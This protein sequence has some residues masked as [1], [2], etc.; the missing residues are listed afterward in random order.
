MKSSF[1]NILFMR[2]EQSYALFVDEVWKQQ[3]FSSLNSSFMQIVADAF[4][5]LYLIDI[6]ETL[7]IFYLNE[8]LVKFDPIYEQAKQKRTVWKSSSVNLNKIYIFCFVI[9]VH[10]T[11]TTSSDSISL[12]EVSAMSLIFSFNF[13]VIPIK[14]IQIIMLDTL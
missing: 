1:L 13:K 7:Y 9:L 8:I 6:F 2:L 14:R 4:I 10:S 12:V 11:W 3:F 5:L